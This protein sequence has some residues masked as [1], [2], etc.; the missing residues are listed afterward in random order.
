MIRV[1]QDDSVLPYSWPR[2]HQSPEAEPP[3][4]H[5]IKETKQAMG[6]RDRWCSASLHYFSR[7]KWGT[8]TP[9]QPGWWSASSLLSPQC[10]HN[11]RGTE[12]PLPHRIS[13]LGPVTQRQ[14]LLA[15]PIPHS[16]PWCQQVQQRLELP[17]CSCSNI[18]VS[19]PTPHGVRTPSKELSLHPPLR[20][21]GFPLSLGMHQQDP[22]RSWTP[23]Q[24]FVVSKGSAF[25]K[26]VS[27]GPSR[28]PNKSTQQPI[29]YTSK[30]DYLLRQN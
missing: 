9:S 16:S 8:K 20:G 23:P 26:V 7:A 6:S 12:S 19:P 3:D 21:N 18:V 29:C 24:S 15:L 4:T 11:P 14:G 28:R 27:V 5:N 10:Q 22:G 30:G 1:S 13:E 17:P 25:A 2:C